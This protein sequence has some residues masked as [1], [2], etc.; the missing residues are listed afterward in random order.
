MGVRGPPDSMV[1]FHV[2][3]VTVLDSRLVLFTDI[4]HKIQR[5][6]VRK[7]SS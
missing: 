5:G 3:C 2:R 1:S 7:I 4:R 6:E